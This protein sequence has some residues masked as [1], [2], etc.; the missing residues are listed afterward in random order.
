MKRDFDYVAMPDY[1]ADTTDLSKQAANIISGLTQQ[2][3]ET[4]RDNRRLL[5][6]AILANGG[7]LEVHDRHMIDAFAATIT[8][9]RDESI[10]ATI[11]KAATPNTRRA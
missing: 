1:A 8:V 5:A 9:T 2:L 4:K 6:A 3:A 7:R 11:Y 10:P